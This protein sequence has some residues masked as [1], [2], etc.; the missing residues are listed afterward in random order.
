MFIHSQLLALS[1][2]CLQL[3]HAASIAAAD[4]ESL[5]VSRKQKRQAEDEI[6]PVNYDPA[7]ISFRVQKPSLRALSDTAQ[8]E[9][10]DF[11]RTLYQNDPNAAHDPQG[12]Y[13]R[14][15]GEDRKRRAIIFRPLFVYKEQ[16][17]RRK[18]LKEPKS[19]QF[20]T[21]KQSAVQVY[22]QA[23]ISGQRQ[24]FAG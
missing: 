22:E 8:V 14:E 9:Y 1:L 18:K 11:L 4:D 15:I 19:K 16:E 6:L 12:R 13:K 7:T 2:A 10:N 5:I 24:Q 17:V 20:A 3:V 21:S 23:I